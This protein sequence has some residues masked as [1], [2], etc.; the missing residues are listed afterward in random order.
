MEE[1]LDL[2]FD[3]L[4]MMIYIYIYIYKSQSLGI[5]RVFHFCIIFFQKVFYSDKYFS[6][7]VLSFAQKGEQV[8]AKCLKLSDFFKK[9]LCLQPVPVAARSKA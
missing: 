2:S 9:K 7:F 3:R 6:Y 8:F 4:L 5:Y 1:A